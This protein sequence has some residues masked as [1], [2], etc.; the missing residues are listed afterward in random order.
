MLTP[1][2]VT[3]LRIGSCSTRGECRMGSSGVVIVGGTSG[4]G[5]ASARRFAADG[6]RVAVIG[7]TAEKVAAAAATVN[8]IGTSPAV[9]GLVADAGDDGAL[10][11]AYATLAD[12][13]PELNV[14]VNAVGP[15]GAGAFEDLDD[16]AWRRVFDQGV[17]TAVRSI[18]HALPQ[19]RRASWARI[20]NI[21]AI[22]TK[23]QTSGLIA[24]TAAK[25]ALASVTKNLARTFASDGILVNA[26]AP[27]PVLTGGIT[28]AV[29]AAGADAGDVYEAYEVMA[30]QYDSSVDLRR[31]GRAEEVAE[32]V[33]FCASRDNSFM[34]GATLNVD[35]GSDFC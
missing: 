23:H 32:A 13:W 5:L 29:R 14:V 16:E 27:G 24:Y 21:T 20:V 8:A 31:V 10:A 33:A 26:V 15:T 2:N 1:W 19:L 18:R 25:A 7:R 4:I 11:A 17:L 22:S 12:A 30:R 35:G 34:T 3:V 9:L 6:A 28:G